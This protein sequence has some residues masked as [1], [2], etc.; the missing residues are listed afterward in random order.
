VGGDLTAATDARKRKGEGTQGQ[1][2][3]RA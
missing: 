1:S 2:Q 3:R